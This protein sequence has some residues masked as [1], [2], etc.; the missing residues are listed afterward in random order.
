M[1]TTEHPT[2]EPTGPTSYSPGPAEIPGRTVW[3]MRVVGRS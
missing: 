2:G 1:L 3:L